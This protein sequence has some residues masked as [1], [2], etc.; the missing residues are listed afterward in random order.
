MRIHQLHFEITSQ[1]QKW[2]KVRSRS[3][4]KEVTEDDNSQKVRSFLKYNT[5]LWV[6]KSYKIISWTQ[7]NLF[8]LRYDDY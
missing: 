8:I 5:A 2:L 1:T 6:L 4:S 7:I 3:L